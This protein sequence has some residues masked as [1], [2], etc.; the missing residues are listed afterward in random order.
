MRSF[1]KK[2]NWTKNCLSSLYFLHLP[3]FCLH[4]LFSVALYDDDDDDDENDRGSKD[5]YSS[6]KSHLCLISGS[7]SKLKT[8]TR[9]SESTCALQPS[10]CAPEKKNLWR[11]TLKNVLSSK[12]QYSILAFAFRHCFRLSSQM[13]L[14]NQWNSDRR[15]RSALKPYSATIK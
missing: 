4:L 1:K 13:R 15:T 10:H 6:K 5:K 12:G 3:G 8:W 2:R 9:V 11:S 14:R 7:G